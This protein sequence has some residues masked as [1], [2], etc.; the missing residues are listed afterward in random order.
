MTMRIWRGWTTPA[1]AD[2]FESFLCRENFRSIV[3]FHGMNVLR[4]DHAD[5][6][7]FMT[8]MTFDSLDAV[9]NF[10]GDRYKEA[11]VPD[12][13]R[14]LLSRFENESRHYELCRAGESSDHSSK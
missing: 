5:E 6:V 12:E 1:N 2:A 10:A 4:L 11:V 7:E 3:G 14:L 8:I 13:A 9:R